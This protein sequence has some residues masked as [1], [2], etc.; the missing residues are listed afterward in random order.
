MIK[1]KFLYNIYTYKLIY[2]ICNLIKIKKNKKKK[3]KK[4]KLNF[5]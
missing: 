1:K 3:K 5:I 4:K 2:L